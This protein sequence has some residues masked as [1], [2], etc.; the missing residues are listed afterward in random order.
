[1][2]I[3]TLYIEKLRNLTQVNLDN[4]GTVNIVFGQNGSGK[5][6][7]L[8]AIYCLGFG[9][10]F[11]TH[12]SKQIV[13]AT[14]EAFTVFAKLKADT[15][16]NREHRIGFSRSRTG[17]S[18]I[19]I[20]GES[21][22]RFSELAQY[23]PVQLITPEGVALVTDGPKARRQFMDWGLFHVEHAQYQ[24]WV[25]Y[26]R[27]LKQR[28]TLLREGK[29]FSD[30]GSYWDKELIKAGDA[31]TQARK[32]YLHSLNEY[33][34]EYTNRF[35]PDIKFEFKL[36]PGWSEKYESFEEAL[37]DKLELDTKQGFT[38]VGPSKAEWLIKADGVDAKERLSRGQLKLLVAALRFVQ[39]DHYK[40]VTGKQCVYLVDDLP[41]EL[42]V[43]NQ[44]KLCKALADTKSQVF[45]T[46]IEKENLLMHFKNDE[47]RL[48]HVEHGTVK[49]ITTG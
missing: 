49:E 46:T 32:A 3:S 48:F 45:V 22:V 8:E 31:L 15:A 28:N 24:H 20:D 19:R 12:Q 11:R 43:I 30:G 27:L 17:E 14:E 23:T 36:L 4:V 34:A 21:R 9:R 38:S 7:V 5:T 18:Q 10:S 44:E 2:H 41:A 40:A 1:M 13:Q 39:G 26:S 37:V 33:L 47:T 16:D 6:S 42:D 25:N 29:Y 35:L